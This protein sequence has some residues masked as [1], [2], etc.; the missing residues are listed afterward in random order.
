[1]EAMQTHERHGAQGSPS[2]CDI[3]VCETRGCCW[4]VSR[5]HVVSFVSLLTGGRGRSLGASPWLLD[6]V[7]IVILSR[8]SDEKREA[9]PNRDGPHAL[10]KRV[11]PP[12]AERGYCEPCYGA[13]T[14]LRTPISPTPSTTRPR[15]RSVVRRSVAVFMTP[16]DDLVAL[17]RLSRGLHC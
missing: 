13:V 4:S 15:L 12:V 7:G 11:A 6:F 5:L 1:M 17:R 16:F 3:A 8:W 10:W 14:P 2:A 9:R